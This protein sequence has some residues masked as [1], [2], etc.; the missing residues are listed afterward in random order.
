MDP[1]AIQQFPPCSY[2]SWQTAAMRQIELS[3]DFFK[4]TKPH[5]SHYDREVESDPMALKT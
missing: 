4:R 3:A 5:T 1:S 2:R